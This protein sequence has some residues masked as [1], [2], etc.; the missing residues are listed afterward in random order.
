MIKSFWAISHVNMVVVPEV[1]EIS[2]SPS[3]GVDV[4]TVL[5]AC[6]IYTQGKL[7]KCP[8]TDNM[9]KRRHSGC[10][11]LLREAPTQLDPVDRASLNHW[12]ALA[13]G[14]N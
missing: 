6:Y 11:P 8:T 10:V 12:T 1:S 4:M 7:S 14:C 9:G 2:L 13:N 3:S 5:F